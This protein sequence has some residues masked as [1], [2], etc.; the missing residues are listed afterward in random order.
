MKELNSDITLK[1]VITRKNQTLRKGIYYSV[2][3]DIVDRVLCMLNFNI[4]F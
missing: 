1:I 4:F 2:S 3:T